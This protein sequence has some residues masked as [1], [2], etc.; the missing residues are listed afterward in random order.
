[1]KEWRDK[2]EFNATLSA[3]CIRGLEISLTILSESFCR[4]YSEVER[5]RRAEGRK[6][7]VE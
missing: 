6:R 2:R 4:L 5:G 3:P 1:L 7:W